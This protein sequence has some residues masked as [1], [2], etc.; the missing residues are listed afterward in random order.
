MKEYFELIWTFIKI[1]VSAFGGGYAMVPIL[2]RELIRGKGWITMDEVMEYYTVAQITPGIIAVNVSTFVGYKRKGIIGGIAATLGFILPGVTL[3]T[4]VSL[5]IS[6]FAEYPVVQHAFAGIRVAVGALIVETV[7]RL[8]KGFYKDAKSLAIFILV[9]ALSAILGA[10][11]MYV[12]LGAGLLGWL[13]YR[14]KKSSGKD[15]NPL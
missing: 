7:I 5:F 2:D 6:R 10:S 15:G 11:P 12:I 4:I 3:M 8:V 1:G 9:F 13:L 14:P